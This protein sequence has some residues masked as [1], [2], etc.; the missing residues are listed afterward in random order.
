MKKLLM[1]IA[2]SALLLTACG[3]EEEAGE[4]GET[5][6]TAA[7][8]EVYTASCLSCHGDNM[9]GASG[10]ALEGYTADEVLSAIEEG[11]GAMPAN[12]VEGEDAQIV[13]AYVEDES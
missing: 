10:P 5:V 9:E 11:P 6:D 1:A 13:A 4:S 3:G 8:E 2:G 12:I 7:G